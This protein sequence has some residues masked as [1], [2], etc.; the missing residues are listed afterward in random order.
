MCPLIDLQTIGVKDKT[1]LII[2]ARRIIAK[3]NLLKSVQNKAMQ[4]EHNIQE[5][6]DTFEQL[7]VKGLPPFWDEKV[8]YT[9]NKTTILSSF[10]V[11]WTIPNF[12]LWRKV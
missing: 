6:K 4:M 11:G 12:N 2:W 1:A 10:S 3:H 7:F 5:F 8:H 9:I